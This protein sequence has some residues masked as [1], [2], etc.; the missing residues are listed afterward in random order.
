[1]SRVI[2]AIIRRGQ[3]ELAAKPNR[4]G[5][6]GEPSSHTDYAV[7]YPGGWADV[8]HGRQPEEKENDLV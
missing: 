5:S 1:M 7:S 2:E 4:P 8:N 3:A 6:G